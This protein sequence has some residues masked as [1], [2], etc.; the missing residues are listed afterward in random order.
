[1]VA[2]CVE[3]ACRCAFEICL[4]DLLDAQEFEVHFFVMTMLPLES[5]EQV[6][7]LISF[8]LVDWKF[9]EVG[10][11]R[12]VVRPTFPQEE[13]AKL[14]AGVKLNRMNSALPLLLGCA[15]LSR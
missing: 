11:E 8:A 7:A 9:D 3:F 12:S 6:S 4:S 15:A 5:F 13:R 14:V 2:L 10:D 1:M